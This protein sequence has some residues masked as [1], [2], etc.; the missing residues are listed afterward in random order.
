MTQ[1]QRRALT[2]VTKHGRD[3]A[4][5]QRLAVVREVRDTYPLAEQP[6]LRD[7]VAAVDWALAPGA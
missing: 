6:L 1:L 2:A 7:I 3:T 4:R 5:T